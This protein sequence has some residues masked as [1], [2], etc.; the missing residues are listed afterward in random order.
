MR[1]SHQGGPSTGSRERTSFRRDGDPGR[2][3]HAALAG[4]Q[5]QLLQ[6]D[7]HLVRGGRRHPEELD[8][9]RLGRPLPM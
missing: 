4:D 2:L 9:I 7:D 3:R 8:Q 6:L 1:T 5:V